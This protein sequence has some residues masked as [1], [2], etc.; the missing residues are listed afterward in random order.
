MKTIVRV[1][2]AL[3]VGGAQQAHAQAC[4]ERITAQVERSL[5]SEVAWLGDEVR[6]HRPVNMSLIGRSV[7]YV[8]VERVSEYGVQPG[9]WPIKTLSFRLQGVG[10]RSGEDFPTPVIRAFDRAYPEAGCERSDR[11]MCEA[12]P[13]LPSDPGYLKR[14]ELIDASI[15]VPD[16]ARGEGLGQ[17]RADDEGSDPAPGFL[18]CAYE[19]P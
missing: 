4:P 3:L 7:P 5:G 11:L 6:G 9:A 12:Y 1:A 8:I 2:T 17:I 10:R 16:N 19:L 13:D 14:V 15:Y 18:V